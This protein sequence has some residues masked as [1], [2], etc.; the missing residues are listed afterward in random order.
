MLK[1]NIPTLLLV[2]LLVSTLLSAC[3]ILTNPQSVTVQ[4]GAKESFELDKEIGAFPIEVREDAELL[5]V[6]I[7]IAVE[8]GSV[9]WRLKTP[10]GGEVMGGQILAG[11]SVD[12]TRSFEAIPGEWLVEMEYFAAKG[13]YD[14][15]WRTR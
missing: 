3:S 13:E 5:E 1:K 9:V 4:G 15:G 2:S 14:L 6:T 10:T 8:S 12:E 11:E 7:K